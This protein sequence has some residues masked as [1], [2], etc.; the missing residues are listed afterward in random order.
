VC[1][2]V[3]HGVFHIRNCFNHAYQPDDYRST[4]TRVCSVNIKC[5]LDIGATNH[6]TSDLDHLAVHDRY[7]D[8][9]K[10]SKWGQQSRFAHFSHR[11]FYGFRLQ[12]IFSS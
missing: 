6:L 4:S 8:K 5:Y 2:N 10:K 12:K 1:R 7:H 9:V 3:E 11:P